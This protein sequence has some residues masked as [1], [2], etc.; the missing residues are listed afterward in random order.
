VLFGLLLLGEKLSLVTVPLLLAIALAY[1]MEPLVVRMTRI[2][3]VSRRFASGSIAV[4]TVFF[5]VVPLVLGVAFATL[6]GID[7][8]GTVARNTTA[9]VASVEVSESVEKRDRL[10]QGAW[11][12]IRDFLVELEA[13]PDPEDTTLLGVDRRELRMGLDYLVNLVR[14]NADRIGKQALST[15]R[16]ALTLAVS[17]FSSVGRTVFGAFLTFFFFFFV[18]A[19]WP[20]FR[21]AVKDLVPD[22]NQEK[23]AASGGPGRKRNPPGTSAAPSI[24]RV[25]T[26]RW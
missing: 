10:G 18:S 3:W 22:E 6:Q 4:A 12:E 8:A 24:H 19:G 23:T 20:R 5:V 17:T 16:D 26:R 21:E 11:L 15:S 13:E 7:F 9:V 1:M 2:S 25:E 14:Q